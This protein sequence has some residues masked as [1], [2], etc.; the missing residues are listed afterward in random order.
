M[1]SPWFDAKRDCDSDGFHQIWVDEI[2]LKFAAAE[3]PSTIPEYM[4]WRRD[5][6]MFFQPLHNWKDSDYEQALRFVKAAAKIG[7]HASL[8]W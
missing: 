1:C 7:G 6:D 8:S 2:A 4:Q 3:L 5:K